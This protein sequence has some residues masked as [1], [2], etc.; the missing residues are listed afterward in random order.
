MFWEKREVKNK[1]RPGELYHIP[2]LSIQQEA[3]AGGHPQVQNHVDY[4]V[5]SKITWATESVSKQ[6]GT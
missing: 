2:N 4:T 6:T 3:E 1:P 5:N